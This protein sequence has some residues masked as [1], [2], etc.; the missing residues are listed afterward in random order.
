MVVHT[1]NLSRWK[2]EADRSEFKASLVY[3]SSVRMLG[4][5]RET[6]SQKIK[7]KKDS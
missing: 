3:R 6:L 5:Y 2:V 7:K 4:L 1:F